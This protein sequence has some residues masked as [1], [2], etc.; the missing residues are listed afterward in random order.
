MMDYIRFWWEYYR[1]YLHYSRAE[2]VYT[3]IILRPLWAVV[4]LWRLRRTR[5][6]MNRG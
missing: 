1:T 2:S 6:P 5:N 4:A 3:I